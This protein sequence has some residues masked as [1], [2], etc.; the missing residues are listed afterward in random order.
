MVWYNP[1]T[2]FESEPDEPLESGPRGPAVGGNNPIDGNNPSTDPSFLGFLWETVKGNPAALESWDDA[3]SMR[4]EQVKK[5]PSQIVEKV[6]SAASSVG[7]GLKNFL[8][9]VIVIAVIGL[10][11]FYFLRAKV[12]KLGAA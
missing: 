4:V 3:Y 11:A 2:W 8:I 6:T 5:L 1:F 7:S 9:W 12:T 10:V